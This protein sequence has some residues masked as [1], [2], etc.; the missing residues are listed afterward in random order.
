MG[1]INLEKEIGK[2]NEEFLLSR[3]KFLLSSIAAMG[4]ASMTPLL[5]IAR[6][7]SPEQSK[8]MIISTLVEDVKTIDMKSYKVVYVSTITKVVQNDKSKVIKNNTYV[9]RG[10]SPQLFEPLISITYADKTNVF[11]Y[12]DDNEFIAEDVEGWNDFAIIRETV[13]KARG[14]GMRKLER[15]AT[16]IEDAVAESKMTS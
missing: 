8:G 7:A 6:A 9:I 16:L 14:K 4:L 13:N 10:M 15:F 12:A 11:A 3:R 5:S 1:V 2:D